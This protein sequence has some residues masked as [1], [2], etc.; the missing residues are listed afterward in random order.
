VR[1]AQFGRCFDL[2]QDL[3]LL[4]PLVALVL[5]LLQQLGDGAL[6]AVVLGELGLRSEFAEFRVH[7]HCFDVSFRDDLL[8]ILQ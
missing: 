4:L 8:V 1:L 2:R 3:G 5:E 7:L 6:A